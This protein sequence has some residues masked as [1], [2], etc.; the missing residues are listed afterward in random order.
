MTIQPEQRR[1]AQL[2]N[3]RSQLAAA[4]ALGNANVRERA[5]SQACVP[6]EGGTQ[7]N[8]VDPLEIRAKRVVHVADECS[9][10]DQLLETMLL[11]EGVQCLLLDGVR[12]RARSTCRFPPF[13]FGD[14][15]AANAPESQEWEQGR[16]AKH[17]P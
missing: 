10:F 9:G 12:R 15:V 5:E 6:R 16:S 3:E 17:R 11:A 1:L 2:R 13:H 8:R 4:V 14:P 7:F